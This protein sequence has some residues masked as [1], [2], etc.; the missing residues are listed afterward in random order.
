MTASCLLFVRGKAPSICHDLGPDQYLFLFL[1][2]FSLWHQAG[3]AACS[4]SLY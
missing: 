2:L 1:F 4:M 3:L